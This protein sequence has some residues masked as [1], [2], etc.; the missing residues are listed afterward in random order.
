MKVPAQTI[1]PKF[2]SQVGAGV[3]RAMLYMQAENNA[4]KSKNSIFRGNSTYEFDVNF[5]FGSHQPKLMVRGK[6]KSDTEEPAIIA[7]IHPTLEKMVDKLFQDIR[8]GKRAKDKE[9]SKQTFDV[10]GHGLNS[11]FILEKRAEEEKK[12]KKE[13]EI[14]SDDDDW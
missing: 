7:K 13:V 8:S 11:I 1:I 10:F 2:K 9:A 6:D 12:K 5:E 4:S 3:Y 14:L